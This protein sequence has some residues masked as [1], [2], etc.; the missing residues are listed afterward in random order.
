[1]QKKHKNFWSIQIFV[2]ILRP[3]LK[4]SVKSGEVVILAMLL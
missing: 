1:M 4:K 3:L 2:V